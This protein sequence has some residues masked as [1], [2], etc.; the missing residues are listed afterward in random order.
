M[1]PSS[2]PESLLEIQGSL[3]DAPEGAALIHAC[4]CRG[5]WGKGIARVFRSNYPAAFEIYRSHCRQFSSE[6]S[7]TTITTSEGTRRARLPEGTALIIPPQKKDYEDG[8]R[9]RHWII[10]LFTS[11]GLGRMVSPANIVLENTELAITDMKKQI[12][13]LEDEK[14]IFLDLRSCRFNSG[15]FGVEWARSRA[16]LEKSGLDITVVRPADE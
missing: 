12:Y 13:Q 15:L 4:N 2:T 7:Y 8:S 10:C 1:A 5:T 14:G 6:A 3:F 11:R 9:K 16:I